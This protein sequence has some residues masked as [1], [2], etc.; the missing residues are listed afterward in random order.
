MN[1]TQFAA[2]GPSQPGGGFNRT[3]FSTPNSVDFEYGVNVVGNRCGVYGECVKDSNR[4]S[5]VT[6]VGVNGRGE[7]IG[8]LGDGRGIASVYGHANRSNIGVLGAA[9]REA[10]GVVGVSMKSIGNPLNTFAETPQAADGEGTGVLGLSG[11]GIGV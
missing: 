2:L 5:I 3:G 10:I 6:G 11:S 7:N 9:M 1:D 8:V 4:E